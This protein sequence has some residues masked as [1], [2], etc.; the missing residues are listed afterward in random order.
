MKTLVR[1]A[2]WTVAALVVLIHPAFAADALTSPEWKA[3]DETVG[4]EYQRDIDASVQPDGSWVGVWLDFRTGY[5]AL[6]LRAFD[7]E[8]S[9]LGPSV[10]LTEGLGLFSL[11]LNATHVGEP[12]LAPIGDGRSLLVWSEG[13]GGVDRIRGAIVGAAGLIQGPITLSD[14]SRPDARFHPRVAISQG[15]ACVVWVEGGGSFQ[16]V[17]GEVVDLQDM[18]RITSLNFPID[19]QGPQPQGACRVAPSAD[20][21]VA[22]WQGYQQGIPIPLILVRKIATDGS[23]AGDPTPV[24]SGTGWSQGQTALAAV[25]EGFFVVWTAASGN[26]IQLLGRVFDANLSGIAPSFQIVDEGTTVTPNTP[27]AIQTGEGSALVVWT[28]GPA[29]RT[30]FYARGIDLPSTPVGNFV[31]VDDPDDP[32]GGLFIPRNLS[33]RGGGGSPA[34]LLWTD[35]REG[36]DLDYFAKVDSAGVR[37]ENPVPLQLTPGSASQL[38]PAISLFP[39]NSGVIVWEDFRTGGLTIF[40]RLL[41]SG[42]TPIGS[43]FRISE[44]SS[45]A[46]SVPATN[47]R[48]MRRNQ[49]A[50]VT[51][52]DGRAVVA[53]TVILGGG[54]SSV[55]LQ[56]LASNGSRIGDN[57]ELTGLGG[58][59]SPQLAALAD[60]KYCIVWRDT[61]VDTD[62]DIIAQRFASDGTPVSDTI[63]V[64]DRSLEE[65]TAQISPAIAA[66]GAGEFV[67]T[68]LDDR[69]GN[70]DVFAQRLASNGHKIE[71]NISISG[72]EGDSPILQANP[73][74]AAASD[75]YVIVWDENPLSQGAI[76]GLLTVLPSARPGLAKADRVTEDTPFSFGTNHAGFKYPRVGM[77]PGGQFIVTYWDTQADSARVMAQRFT[78]SGV[79][80]GNP[81]PILAIDGRAAA[82]PADVTARANLIQYAYADS[83]DELGWDIR[84][85]RV[86]WN[87]EGGYTPVLLEE[88]AID[89]EAGAI[90]LRWSAPV[91]LSGAVY[92]IWRSAAGNAGQ[93]RPGSD[94]SIVSNGFIGPTVPGGADYLF[95][96]GSASPGS[97]YA[98]W[99]ENAAGDFSGPW[100]ATLH[101]PALTL[102]VSR[103]P[104][105]ESVAFSWSAPA[106]AAASI[107]IYDAT[108]RLVRRVALDTALSTRGEA[109]WDGRDEASRNVP[110][111]LYWAR[112][113][114][115]PGGERT[116]RI[117]RLR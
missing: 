99:I 60:A 19:P 104:F 26:R 64:A 23:L 93:G 108:G 4:Q 10:R 39:D 111:G 3:N 86:D 35:N 97:P 107:T 27:E 105:R 77:E 94:A 76:A 33:V 6:F 66:N 53:W 90:V 38:L 40:G 62:G 32:P 44:G 106:R 41:D 81:Y 117:L 73:A 20:G 102:H 92:R 56:H 2:G 113:A 96:D 24:D 87:F 8:D 68:W 31:V 37:T 72:D 80:A 54:R 22:A 70:Q 59:Q 28:A 74:V 109:I 103:N 7:G 50:V 30:R 48:D 18:E 95:R 16:S 88:H 25:P 34:R 115:R 42:G 114:A 61:G 84:V 13:R 15:R 58:A 83:R 45:G 57:V 5:P 91:D 100:T 21:W 112:L 82:I 101:A 46:V 29:S 9:P 65:E 11:D 63:H 49:P 89:E 116:A 12:S 52:S 55:M 79:R 47:L 85:R 1:I 43:A 110:A 51:T 14:D 67:V 71:S 78:A 98:Y 36:W 75:R 17:Y 69:R